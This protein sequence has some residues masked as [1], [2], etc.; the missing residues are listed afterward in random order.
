[1]MDSMRN[2]WILTGI[3]WS[4]VILITLYNASEIK[5]LKLAREEIETLRMD[6][7]FW[8]QHSESTAGI[9]AEGNRLF[10][11]VESVDLGLLTIGNHAKK[12][13][14]DRRLPPI[15]LNRQ[16]ITALDGQVPVD[17]SFT[18]SFADAFSWFQALNK[19][20]PFLKAVNLRISIDPVSN[21]AVTTGSFIFRYRIAHGD[22]AQESSGGI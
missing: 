12:L 16:P 20:M 14:S 10:L 7:Q 11:D 9:S 18:G 21:K 1:M 17:I 8:Q 6:E 15:T 5:R 3:V 4:A 13:S 2:K 22:G 19:E